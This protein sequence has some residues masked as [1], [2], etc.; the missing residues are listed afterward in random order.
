MRKSITC[1][2]NILY[3]LL[4]VFIYSSC[5]ETKDE[6]K[7]AASPDPYFTTELEAYQLASVVKPNYNQERSQTKDIPYKRIK[8]IYLLQIKMERT[9]FTL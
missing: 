5:S 6:E 8:D 1:F 7:E 4:A 3:L 9:P 2:T